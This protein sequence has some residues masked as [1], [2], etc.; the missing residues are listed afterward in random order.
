MTSASK[1]A[2]EHILCIYYPV[3]FMDTDKAPVQ[4]LID[5]GNEVNAIYLFFVKPLGFSIRL[6]DVEA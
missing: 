5:S 2:L 6:T 3:Q 1:E 4:A